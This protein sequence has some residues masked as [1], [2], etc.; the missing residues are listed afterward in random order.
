[1][2]ELPN[3]RKQRVLGFLNPPFKYDRRGGY[4]WDAS[5]NTRMVADETL[6]HT[7]RVR[8]WGVIS[9]QENP[10]QLQ[11]D[12]GLIIVEALNE[13]WEKHSEVEE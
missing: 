3:E 13:Y 8:G 6:G 4:I 11:D 12:I 10:E 5:M 7:L 1:M 9:K 2:S